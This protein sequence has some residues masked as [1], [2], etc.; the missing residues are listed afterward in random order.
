MPCIHKM[1]VSF[2]EITVPFVRIK[3][4]PAA[5]NSIARL[6]LA[7]I[8]IPINQLLKHKS[9]DLQYFS[10]VAGSYTVYL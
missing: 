4:K 8:G 9:I 5:V 6:V 7:F 10:I 1:I 3:W 2:Y